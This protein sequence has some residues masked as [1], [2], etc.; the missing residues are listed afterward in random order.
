MLRNFGV[1]SLTAQLKVENSAQT[2]SRFSPISYCAPRLGRV[3]NSGSGC[4]YAMHLLYSI[5]IWPNLGLKTR[6]KQLLGYI[7]LDITLPS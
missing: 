7:L 3:L 2:T 4:K 5:A 1:V 6:L